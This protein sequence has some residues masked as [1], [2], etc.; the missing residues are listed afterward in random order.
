MTFSL[1]ELSQ[2]E[3]AELAASRVPTGIRDKLEPGSMPPPH[4]TARSLALAASGQSLPWSTTFL[5]LDNGNDKIVGSCGFKTGPRN[6]RVEIGY[7]VA[8]I[9]QGHG[10][11][12]KAI[13]LM[14]QKAFGAGAKEVLAE[15][16]PENTASMR[17]VQKAGFEQIGSRFDEQNEYVIQ[18]A[19]RSE[20]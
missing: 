15:I 5:I 19:K 16:V 18:W 4:V 10:A 17:V 9:A 7:G 1:I 13:L 20:A 14:L 12:T 6:G 8:P 3:L 2:F 11:A